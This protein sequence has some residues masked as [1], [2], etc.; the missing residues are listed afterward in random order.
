[1]VNVVQTYKKALEKTNH[2]PEF[3]ERMLGYARS[4]SEKGLPVVY[5]P[6]HLA[7]H[8]GM[9]YWQLVRMAEMS[10][11]H[12]NYFLISKKR[13]GKRRVIAPYADIREVQIWI[14]QRIL[15]KQ[16]M[17]PC[18]TGFVKKRSTLNNAKQHEN[19]KFILKCDIKDFFESIDVGDVRV[20]F[21][22]IGYSKQV[23]YTLAQLCTTKIN[24][25][26]YDRME[27]EE[28]DEFAPL[29]D[30][31]RPFLV[32]GAPTSPSIA[33]LVCRYIDK[34]F[35]GYCVKHNVKYTRYADDMIFSADNKEDLPSKGFIR[36]VLRENGF[37]LNEEKTQLM[38]TPE[39]QFVT[40]LLVDGHV[41]VPGT[42]KREI[43]RHLHFCERF[44]GRTH[45][46]H[47][48]SDK[49][50]NREWLYGKIYYVNAIEPKE[51]KKMLE[52]ADR[53]RWM[54]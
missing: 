22:K 46:A 53:V 36:K 51:G 54:E 40:G 11:I 31:L 34:R 28:Q 33:N 24:E 8:L 42:F 30:H 20:L 29:L 4:L 5:S 6:K 35:M 14:K 38:I 17:L 49:L 18:V 10:E 32:Q 41:R 50:F 13:G 3:K 16:A 48:G 44:G 21:H 7:L 15:D 45:F 27:D 2:S 1:M 23:A 43:Y 19:K 26:K 39:R 52:I 37:V 47:L 9:E 12:Y 25:W